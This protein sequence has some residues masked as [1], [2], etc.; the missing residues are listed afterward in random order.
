MRSLH[1]HIRE[2][3]GWGTWIRTKIDGVRVAHNGGEKIMLERKLG[4]TGPVVS[5]I[6]LG[7][8]GMSDLYGPA[9]RAESI[10]TIHAARATSRTRRKST[11]AST[12]RSSSQNFG[13]LFRTG[14]LA[15]GASGNWHRSAGSAAP[16]GEF[17]G[18]AGITN[19]DA[20]LRSP[21]L[22]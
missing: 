13:R 2:V 14:S 16:G 7:C 4:R 9:D 8:M 19:N 10:A 20:K 6:G 12:R 15:V 22:Q 18:L 17:E 11:P 21:A 3:Y 1:G 5:A